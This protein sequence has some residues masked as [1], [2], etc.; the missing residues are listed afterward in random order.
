MARDYVENEAWDV[1][2][3]NMLVNLVSEQMY[4]WNGS[5][6]G[7]TVTTYYAGASVKKGNNGATSFVLFKEKGDTKFNAIENLFAK[8]DKSVEFIFRMIDLCEKI[9]LDSIPVTNLECWQHIPPKDDD[10]FLTCFSSLSRTLFLMEKENS[11]VN[12]GICRKDYS[13]SVSYYG[14]VKVGDD[15]VYKAKPAFEK[16]D[17]VKNIMYGYIGAGAML[18]KLHDMS[19]TVMTSIHHPDYSVEKIY[20]EREMR[21]K[22]VETEEDGKLL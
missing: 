12:I 3:S 21:L 1:P 18:E 19:W 9:D 4:K 2:N 11:D 20:G 16:K 5:G 13:G 6:S 8:I 22:K 15:V 17:V 14:E 7:E 10:F